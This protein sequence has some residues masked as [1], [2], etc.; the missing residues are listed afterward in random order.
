MAAITAVV[1]AVAM[2]VGGAMKA[3]SEAS[4]AKKA[5]ARA[6]FKPFDLSGPGGSVSFDGQDI[7]ATF[8][9]TQQQFQ[10]IFSQ[11]AA[12]IAGGNAGSQGFVNFGN[13]VGSNVG[14]QF[15]GAQNASFNTPDQAFQ[16]FG[17]FSAQNAQFGQGAGMSALAAANQ[18]GQAQTG[19]N[20]GA[21]QG[22]FGQ[23]FNA[24]NNSNFD[25]NV[26]AMIDRQ[27]AFARPG[28]DRAVNSKFQNLF[29]R[30]ALSSTGGERQLGELAL[31]QELAD[32]Q[33][34][35]SGEQFGQQLTQ[36]NRQFGL[37]AIQQGFGARQQDSQFNLGRANLFAQQGQQL[38]NFGGQQAQA[39]LNSAVGQSQLGNERAQQRLSNANTQFGFGQNADQQNINQLLQM[40]GG[41][42]QLNSDIRNQTALAGNISAQAA[43]ANSKSAQFLANSGQSVG[44]SFLSG[45]GQGLVSGFG[46]GGAG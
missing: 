5:A 43:A 45:L 44:G 28:E 17:N 20:E 30:G 33:R 31:S 8:D 26:S 9:P 38:M 4:A 40:F 1:G 41:T 42:S 2:G 18:F 14:Q 19:Q 15:Q 27:R 23:G 25:D 32:I 12:N 11:N 37:S 6:K 7:S 34:V 39:G 3:K 36:Q 29:N 10:D 24:L 35:N 46:P 16:Q 13:Q 21:A 22:L